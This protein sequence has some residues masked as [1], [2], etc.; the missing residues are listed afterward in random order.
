MFCAILWWYL[1]PIHLQKQLVS[2]DHHICVSSEFPRTCCRYYTHPWKSFLFVL[3][4]ND[5]R[6]AI[7]QKPSLWPFPLQSQH[8][9]FLNL[10]SQTKCGSSQSRHEYLGIA[11]EFEP[12]FSSP[13]VHYA[14]AYA[15]PLRNSPGFLTTLTILV[16]S[17]E[18]LYFTEQLQPYPS[19]FYWL[20]PAFKDQTFKLVTWKII[21]FEPFIIAIQ[22]FLHA[23]SSHRNSVSPT[24]DI[25]TSQQKANPDART[26]LRVFS[27]FRKTNIL[28]ASRHNVID[29]SCM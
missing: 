27:Q 10:H 18:Y 4:N 11:L 17:C 12:S 28:G 14:P 19:V 8:L 13:S 22:P 29:I 20:Q 25:Y 7:S 1:K 9:W 2:I 6:L 21:E 16:D 3:S 24:A 23:W 5:F 15:L 26:C